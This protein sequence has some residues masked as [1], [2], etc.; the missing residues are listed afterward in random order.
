M[1][2]IWPV[3]PF[4]IQLG[5][6][7]SLFD[8]RNW[9]WQMERA[10]NIIAA[11]EHHERIPLITASHLLRPLSERLAAGMCRPFP[12]LT[13]LQLSGVPQSQTRLPD[14]FLGG[15]APHLRTLALIGI[16][17]PALPNLLLSATDLVHLD[18]WNIPNSAY[19]P[20]DEMVVC[21]S[22][23]TRLKTLYLGFCPRGIHGT[24]R[25]LPP[26]TRSVPLALT[27]LW[28]SGHS[29]YLGDLIS[30]ID[31]P[32]LNDIDITFSDL[33]P[34]STPQFIQFINRT[35][36]HN[37]FNR[38]IVRFFCNCVEVTLSSESL[39]VDRQSASRLR[40]SWEKPCWQIT[41]LLQF[42]R[43]SLPLPLFSIWNTL[44]STTMRTNGD[45]R[46]TLL[47]GWN[48]YACF[49]L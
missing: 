37:P 27:T 36:I 46:R 38:A 35:E 7:E 26:L 6:H 31:A 28:F 14:L 47:S 24:S 48:F 41:F 33:S 2:D 22:T 17:F 23:L 30:R 9:E 3:L 15:S 13:S 29:E 8:L 32:Q 40:V 49:P 25:P 12:T 10:D 19:I 42:C 1:L 34:F 43:S 44:T 20:P 18:L 11:L 39:R 5:P 45:A 16:S 21:L 4:V